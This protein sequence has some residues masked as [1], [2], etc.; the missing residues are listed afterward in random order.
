MRR[1]FLG[2]LS[3]MNIFTLSTRENV[4]AYYLALHCILDK[5]DIHQS[6]LINL[7][8]LSIVEIC[9]CQVSLWSKLLLIQVRGKILTGDVFLYWLL[10]TLEFFV[11]LLDLTRQLLH[12][13]FPTRILLYFLL[14]DV[15]TVAILVMI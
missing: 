7:K 8:T 13:L 12:L 3:Y 9:H 1:I 5:L 4:L 6:L 15:A 2:Y 11:S 10:D 14:K